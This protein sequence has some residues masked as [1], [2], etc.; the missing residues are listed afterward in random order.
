ME[1]YTIDKIKTGKGLA[2]SRVALVFAPQNASPGSLVALTRF[3]N[4]QPHLRAIP[5]YHGPYQQHVL[6]V[7]GLR[8]DTHFLSLL[9][10]TFPQWLKEHEE[11]VSIQ[12]KPG[13]S[14]DPLD[15]V[16]HFPHQSVMK[17]FVKENT[18]ALTG[19]AYI[20]GNIGLLYSAWLKPRSMPFATQHDWFKTYS[21]VAY[22]AG[23]AALIALGH[24]ADRPRDV[25]SLMENVYPKLR[26]AD[27]NQ[28]AEIHSTAERTLAFLK[29]HPW[30]ISSAINASGA[31]AHLTSATLRRNQGGINTSYEALSALGTLTAM[32]IATLVPEKE[33]RDVSGIFDRSDDDSMLATVN[34][35][36][37]QERKP[38]QTAGIMHRLA[39]W[40]QESPLAV[41]AGIQ[42]V[43]NVG[44]GVA[45]IKRAQ[46][47]PGLMA[48]S[49]AYL[50]GNILQTQATKGR[51]PGFDDI[52]TA[53][54]A[55]IHSDPLLA[56]KSPQEI[57]R[58]IARFAD[59]LSDEQEVVHKK[60]RMDKGIKERL[61]RYKLPREQENEILTGFVASEKRILKDSPFVKPRYVDKVLA[62]N[63]EGGESIRMT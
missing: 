52:V 6:R 39:D 19:L 8:D 56:G 12:L 35:L 50:A 2:G 55:I 54:A 36:K 51:G 14:C 5:G 4:E 37:E 9:Q 42:A 46:T 34:T 57:D 58:Q 25:Y 53:A 49:G 17:R 43:S 15:E 32:S 23:S 11:P 18:N 31:L 7:S 13:T 62:D 63:P 33:G 48:M 60:K 16:S 22:T 21:A 1:N 30:E 20:V 41:S 59:I 29:N 24:K 28:R 45:G 3:L 26:H 38:G 10:D 61:E 40:V 44:Y 27:E 47:D